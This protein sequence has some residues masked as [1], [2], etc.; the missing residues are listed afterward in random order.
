VARVRAAFARVALLTFFA[1][2][3]LRDAFARLEEVFVAGGM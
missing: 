1:E 3:D 2:V